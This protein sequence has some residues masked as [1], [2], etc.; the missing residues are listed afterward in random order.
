[1]KTLLSVILALEVG[2][3]VVLQTSIAGVTTN[4]VGDGP[5]SGSEARGRDSLGTVNDLE[6]LWPN[7][8]STFFQEAAKCADALSGRAQADGAAKNAL[9]DLFDSAFRKRCPADEKQAIVC[10]DA[11]TKMLMCCMNVAEIRRDKSR[12]LS[13]AQ[14]LGEVRER[15]I[16]EYRDR[17]TRFPG[18]RI[19]WQAGVD[20]SSLTNPTL[21]TAYERDMRDNDVNVTMD[22][23]QRTLRQ[24]DWSIAYVLF[25]NARSVGARDVKFLD[26]VADAAH[27]SE[28]ERKKLSGPDENA[29]GLME[30]G[31]DTGK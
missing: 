4:D 28:Q 19:L 12:L 6:R 31:A 2:S 11:K 24:I 22:D 30:S 13:I 26:R 18:E 1:M 14:F 29:V 7:E 21:R 20:A 16:P 23:L 27:L 9:L 8:P 10:F 3:R 25:G 17:G 5:P 15:K